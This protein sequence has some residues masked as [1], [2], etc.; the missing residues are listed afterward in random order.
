MTLADMID[1]I[2][3]SSANNAYLL[4]EAEK[5]PFER[6]KLRDLFFKAIS[7]IQEHYDLPFDTWENE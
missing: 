5:N 7:E 6:F 1:V 3:S 2:E 4:I